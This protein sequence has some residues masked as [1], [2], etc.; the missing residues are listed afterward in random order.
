VEK[1][2]ADAVKNITE[3]YQKELDELRAEL[4]DLKA[5]NQTLQNIQQKQEEMDRR[6]QTKSTNLETKVEKLLAI[7]GEQ[8]VPHIPVDQDFTRP[9][10]KII[11]GRQFSTPEKLSPI[12]NDNRYSALSDNDQHDN[13][14]MDEEHEDNVDDTNSWD[15]N[16]PDSR[17][18]ITF[19]QTQDTHPIFD[20][21]EP[22]QQDNVPRPQATSKINPY[23]PSA[24]VQRL[25]GRGSGRDHQ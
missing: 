1:S 7:L 6:T 5:I 21:T 20:H 12:I 17:H 16:D 24:S 4:Q 2:I 22:N 11:K 10:K 18:P 9:R 15:E 13:D 8:T 25:R 14:H 3:K 19:L 23:K